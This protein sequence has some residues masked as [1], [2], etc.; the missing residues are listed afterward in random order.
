MGERTVPDLSDDLL[1]LMAE[2]RLDLVVLSNP[3]TVYY[4]SG[5]LL[6]PAVP[7]AF[8]IAW[9][10]IS[11][12]SLTGSLLL[13]QAERRIIKSKKVMSLTRINS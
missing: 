4:F 8:G 11:E 7:Q 9:S 5:A 3:K 10:G 6:D 12:I 2:H 13:S 1:G